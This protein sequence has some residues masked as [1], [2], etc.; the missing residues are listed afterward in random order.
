MYNMRAMA[1]YTLFRQHSLPSFTIVGSLTG[2]KLAKRYE[3][4][5]KKKVEAF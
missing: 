1:F 2:D 5:I 4:S 3:S